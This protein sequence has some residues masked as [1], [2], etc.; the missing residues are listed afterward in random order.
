VCNARGESSE[1]RSQISRKKA[2]KSD[3]RGNGE[4]RGRKV[5]KIDCS[6][7][8]S[9]VI[10]HFP[11]L[12][13]LLL[14]V[15]LSL[16]RQEQPAL[17]QWILPPFAFTI[18][19]GVA[20]AIAFASFFATNLAT[21]RTTQS[22]PVHSCPALHYP[23]DFSPVLPC[24]ALSCRVQS[25]PALHC[26]TLSSPVQSSVVLS[27]RALPCRVQ[28]SPVLPCTALPSC[29]ALV[30]AQLCHNRLYFR[31]RITSSLPS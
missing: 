1:N 13:V 2:C 7:V 10:G 22:S 15:P 21:H 20:S 28:S 30:T 12:S 18:A 31:H 24:T 3:S 11:S 19:S 25:T 5:G 8:G 17:L 14:L 26:T 6:S 27:S 23:A 9:S 29:G 4:G 16:P